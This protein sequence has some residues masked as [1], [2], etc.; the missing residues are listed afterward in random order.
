MN[1]FVDDGEEERKVVGRR[2]RDELIGQR[3]TSEDA[4][5]SSPAVSKQCRYPLLLSCTAA[6]SL[7]GMSEADRENCPVGIQ[8]LDSSYYVRSSKDSVYPFSLVEYCSEGSFSSLT[9]RSCIVPF[10]KILLQKFIPEDTV[11]HSLR[12]ELHSDHAWLRTRLER[13]SLLPC[14]PC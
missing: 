7:R 1:V 2:K 6:R 9:I 10:R 14:L 11:V 5:A 13:A 3:R 4:P 12:T 8:L